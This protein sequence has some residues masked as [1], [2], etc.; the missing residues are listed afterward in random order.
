MAPSSPRW[1]Y[2]GTTPTIIGSN[3]TQ[4]GF[5]GGVY[6]LGGGPFQVSLPAT[7]P[8]LAA[9]G[10]D[11]EAISYLASSSG[12]HPC[13]YVASNN[14]RSGGGVQGRLSAW[15]VEPTTGAVTGV[16][17]IDSPGAGFAH[18]GLSRSGRNLLAANY[19]RGSVAVYA[20]RADGG[21]GPL[22]CEVMHEGN[23]P[24]KSRQSAPHPH[25]VAVDAET[26]VVLVPDLGADRLVAYGLDEERGVLGLLPEST[27]TLPAGSGPRHLVFLRGGAS[28][29]LANEL[30]G[31][32]A[33]LSRE[34]GGRYA[35]T[36][37]VRSSSRL[38]VANAPSGVRASGDGELAYVANRGPNTI[39]VFRA[40]RSQLDAIHETPCGGDWPRDLF[41]DQEAGRMLIA[42]HR[43]H[44]VTALRLA[45][46]GLPQDPVGSWKVNCP[47]CLVMAGAG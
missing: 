37:I 27:V 15:K 46:S 2:V 44:E 39:S 23:G 1:Q 7:V 29:V 17:A 9:S 5:G 25:M 8:R 22:T 13:L 43:S 10:R 35:V 38:G 6:L 30:A 20:L 12:A 34:R 14:K 32:V 40:G 36:D 42:N 19:D 26:G 24:V 16:S 18:L 31:T 33:L 21:V 11:A 4:P 41:L 28:A 3:E 47:N 45:E